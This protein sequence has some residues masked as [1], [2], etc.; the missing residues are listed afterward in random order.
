MPASAAQMNRFTA[1][2]YTTPPGGWSSVPLAGTLSDSARHEVEAFNPAN[3][4][5]KQTVAVM[6]VLKQDMANRTKAMDEQIAAI[7]NRI[8]GKGA[9]PAKAPARIYYDSSGKPIQK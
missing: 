9:E 1:Y 2:I 5:L 6:R 4:T 7:K 8:G 3:A